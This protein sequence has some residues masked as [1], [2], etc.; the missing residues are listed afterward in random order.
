MAMEYFKDHI[1]NTLPVIGFFNSKDFISFKQICDP[2]SSVT[3]SGE[4][5]SSSPSP[6]QSNMVLRKGIRKIKQG[7]KRYFWF[8]FF[9]QVF[10]FFN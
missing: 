7:M 8:N 9:V 3:L 1:E 4:L 2:E 10:K 6:P 5:S